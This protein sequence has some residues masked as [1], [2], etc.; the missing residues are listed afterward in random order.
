M[1]AS[2]L[3]SSE[4]EELSGYDHV[5]ALRA[6]QRLVSHFQAQVYREMSLISDL[7]AEFDRDPECAFDSAASEIGAALHLTRRAADSELG[8]ALA[9]RQRLPRV[10]EALASA[11]I[12]M[13]RA[14]VIVHG[15]GHL[16]GE[17]ARQVVDKVI[18][19]ATRMTSGQLYSLVRRACIQADPEEAARRYEEAV[20]DRRVISEPAM[21]GTA[22]LIGLDL[23]PDRVAAAMRHL[24]EW[25]RRLKTADE[26]RTIDQ[27][28]AD[29][30]L[31]LLG[32]KSQSNHGGRGTV[33][34]NVDLQTLAGLA[35]NPG[36]LAGYGPVIAD[37]ARQVAEQQQKSEWRW[38]VTDPDTGLTIHT[39]VT[40]R[41]PTASQRRHVEGRNRTCI[42]PGCRMPANNCDLDHRIPW[43][44]GGP[45]TVDHLDPL[46]RH[47]HVVRH[48]SGWKRYPL[49]GG[50]HLWISPLGHT[51]TTSGRS[52]P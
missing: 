40:R 38:S 22:N 13:R 2:F 28:R 46:C 32:G 34:I 27:L 20:A 43:A 8:F 45:T 4:T 11:D 47:H 24:T 35:E 9:L 21:G 52:P 49:P 6:Y 14:K 36:E 29:I 12:D 5:V 17:T 25:A 51:Y 3:S 48:R 19:P 7:M 23:P 16:P 15:T 30:L 41:R 26:S 18:E 37:I 39:G 42:F 44:Q 1:L 50:D 31:D 10:W 33:D